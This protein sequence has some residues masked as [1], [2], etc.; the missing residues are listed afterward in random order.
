MCSARRS[1]TPTPQGGFSL[2]WTGPFM[3]V[4]PPSAT[5]RARPWPWPPG[6]HDGFRGCAEQVFHHCRNAGGL[7]VLL[8]RR[9]RPEARRGSGGQRR[10]S[11]GPEPGT[12]LCMAAPLHRGRKGRRHLPAGER[13][14]RDDQFYPLKGKTAWER[15][16]M[17]FFCVQRKS[18]GVEGVFNGAN[19]VK[20]AEAEDG[21][22]FSRRGDGGAHAFCHIAAGCGAGARPGRG[23]SQARTPP[24]SGDSAASRRRIPSH[25]ASGADTWSA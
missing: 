23:I 18:E 19:H 6:G 4:P 15:S 9:L 25:R 12:E 8:E 20:G 3:P 17:P 1:I 7:L 2:R 22:V 13:I 14:F 5:S 24:A 21:A 10:M 11:D 16:P